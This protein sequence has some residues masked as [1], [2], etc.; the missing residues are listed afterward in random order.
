VAQT[1]ETFGKLDILVP[2]AAVQLHDRD[3]PLHDLDEATWDETH[4]VNLK[5]VFL[6]CRA[7]LRRMI[8]QGSGGAIVIVSSVAALGGS[9]RNMAYA[10]SKSGLLSLGRTI[11]VTYASHGI[12]C[13][14][15]CPGAL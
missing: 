8:A 4:A 2:N 12:R 1:V 13:N 7:G 3:V 5:G 15:V 14:V 9:S 10:S 11:A 6:T